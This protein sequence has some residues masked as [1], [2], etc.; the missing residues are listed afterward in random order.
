MKKIQKL[1]EDCIECDFCTRFNGV[2]NSKVYVCLSDEVEPFLLDYCE[3][4]SN[5]MPIP[6]HC[7]LISFPS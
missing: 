1:I 6:E 7:P 2:N 4:G 3:S 5:K